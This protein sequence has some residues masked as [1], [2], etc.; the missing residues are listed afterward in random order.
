MSSLNNQLVCQVG[1]VVHNIEETARQWAKILEIE[2]PPVIVTGPQEE[3]HT[4][5]RGQGTSARAK[6][7]FISMGQVNIEL[8]EPG[9]EP[10]TWREF[11]DAHGQGIH[12]I[13]FQINGMKQTIEFLGKQK[14]PLVQKG[15]YQG[16]R[17]AYIDAIPQLGVIL[18]LLEN[19]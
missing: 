19:D 15:D 13:A 9:P 6:L 16:G 11:L 3:A 8:I 12:H 18:E 2:V 10:S 4:E 1:L 14:M 17:Y 7:A 5:Y